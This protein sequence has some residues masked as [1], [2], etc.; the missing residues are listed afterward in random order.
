MQIKGT[1][2]VL[3]LPHLLPIAYLQ[4][5]LPPPLRPLLPTLLVPFT[6]DQIQSLGLSPSL[7]DAS[8]NHPVMFELGYQNNSGPPPFGMSFGEAKLEILGMRHPDTPKASQIVDASH[9][10]VY[11]Q[12]ILFDSWMLAV[13]SDWVAG[14]RSTCVTISP[15]KAPTGYPAAYEGEVQ[16]NVQGYL[17]ASLQRR[18][19]QEQQP[20]AADQAIRWASRPWFGAKTAKGV[21][22]Q[23]DFD[24]ASQPFE[25]VAYQGL[26][27]L[28]PEAFLDPSLADQPVQ[29]L[30]HQDWIDYEGIK[31][32]RFKASYVSRDSKVND[33][34]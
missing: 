14:L 5:L 34:V 19:K 27:R 8:S 32:W 15:A 7:Y 4:Q 3:L 33:A 6:H 16:Y 2:D 9:A 13:S 1:Y 17:E 21:V 30:P 24:S 22:T 23:F 26:L 31:A 12:Q 20:D 29:G 28:R 25:P 11:K 10:F 18:P